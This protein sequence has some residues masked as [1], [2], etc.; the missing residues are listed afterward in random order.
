VR[1]LPLLPA[2]QPRRFNPIRSYDDRSQCRPGIIYDGWT[3]LYKYPETR[4]I[5]GRLPTEALTIIDTACMI[6]QLQIQRISEPA[7]RHALKGWVHRTLL[8]EVYKRA[9]A[10]ISFS[11]SSV[12]PTQAS[13]ALI[14]AAACRVPLIHLGALEADDFRAG[15]V[16]Q[17][18]SPDEFVGDIQEIMDNPLAR[19]VAAHPAWRQAHANHSFADRLATICKEIGIRHDGQPVPKATLVTGTMRPHLLEK[20]VRQYLDQTYP[21]K[22]LVV[23]FNGPASELAAVR[24]KYGSRNDIIF[25]SLPTD[26]HAGSLLNL[27][28]RLGSGKYFFRV[29]D[30]D[31]YGPNYIHDCMLHLRASDVDIFGKRASFYHFDEDDSLYML[32]N[33]LY[34]IV[35]FS[36]K[37]LQANQSP[38]ISGCSFACKSGLLK[39]ISYPDDVNL[40]A[41]TEFLNRIQTIQTDIQ[42]LMVDSLNLVVE[43]SADVENHTW[44]QPA[45]RLKQV[46]QALDKQIS[47]L[48]V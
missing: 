3:D 35:Q 30:D 15:F 32:K 5:L 9:D 2:I 19:E 45:S 7:L 44:R 43:R 28:A 1:A 10:Y 29:D 22:E 23:V 41:D 13:W 47:D 16:R 31:H 18:L 11:R 48:M 34:D 46:S 37:N 8:P 4:A 26:C 21:S 42:C 24:A 25:T 6:A 12:T 38:I 39:E 17:W 20:S 14:E 36:A 27:G 40:S 33:T